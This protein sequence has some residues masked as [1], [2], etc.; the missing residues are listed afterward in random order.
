MYCQ[1]SVAKRSDPDAAANLAR[2]SAVLGAEFAETY[3]RWLA[4]DTLAIIGQAHGVAYETIHLRLLRVH[5]L[6]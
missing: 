4:G 5:A 1:R 2:V 6:L 3:Q